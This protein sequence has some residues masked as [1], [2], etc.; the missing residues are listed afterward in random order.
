MPLF[1]DFYFKEGIR[2]LKTSFTKITKRPKRKTTIQIFK[3]L[4]NKLNTYERKSVDI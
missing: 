3:S 1:L 4:I 2:V